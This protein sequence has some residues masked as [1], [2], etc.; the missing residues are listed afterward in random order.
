M[1][2][3]GISQTSAAGAPSPAT[4]PHASVVVIAADRVAASR[5][6]GRQSSAD[7]QRGSLSASIAP[8]SG[9]GRHTADISRRSKSP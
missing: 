7:A 4:D 5:A 6:P 2:R 9:R 1:T 3:H 8:L